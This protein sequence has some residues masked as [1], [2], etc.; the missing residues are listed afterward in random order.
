MKRGFCLKIVKNTKIFPEIILRKNLLF[1]QIP[2]FHVYFYWFYYR[3]LLKN[4]HSA[5]YLFSLVQAVYVRE[6]LV[7]AGL[8]EESRNLE[9]LFYTA[10]YHDAFHSIF[11][12]GDLAALV[13]TLMRFIFHVVIS[14]VTYQR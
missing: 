9:L 4:A 10:R 1:K 12:M 5:F 3:R 6:W 2:S 8:E 11:P 7:K 14:T 13:S